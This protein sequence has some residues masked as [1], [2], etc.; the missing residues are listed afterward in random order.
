MDTFPGQYTCNTTN[1]FPDASVNS[2]TSSVD[3]YIMQDIAVSLLRYPIEDFEVQKHAS[4][5]LT[6][7]VEGGREPHYLR[8]KQKNILNQTTIHALYDADNSI[9]DNNVIFSDHSVEQEYHTATYIHR[10][11]EPHS[12][13]LTQCRPNRNDESRDSSLGYHTRH[14]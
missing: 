9:S 11:R 5:S 4:M 13:A 14:S 8:L 12:R 2:D 3:I 1:T 6:C 7:I 10:V